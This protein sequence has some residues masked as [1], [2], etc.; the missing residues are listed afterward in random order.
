MF[1][2]LSPEY[3]VNKR[4]RSFLL[5]I[6]TSQNI[7]PV[8]TRLLFKSHESKA[9]IHVYEEGRHV[10]FLNLS[11]ILEFFG[12]DYKESQAIALQNYLQQVA[13]EEGIA[14]SSLNL[15]ICETKNSI[16][17]HIYEGSK[18]RRKISTV[19]LVAHFLHSQHE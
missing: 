17:A 18:Y 16:G 14:L 19:D 1:E 9:S 15:V 8:K 3:Q 4:I 12:Q 11:S 13:A 10:C 2:K 5:H 7:D 6:A